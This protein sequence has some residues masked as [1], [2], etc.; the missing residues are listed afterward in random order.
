MKLDNIVHLFYIEKDD[1]R[2][3]VNT[4]DYQQTLHTFISEPYIFLIYLRQVPITKVYRQ[5]T[6]TLNTVYSQAKKN[7]LVSE[8]ASDEEKLQPGSRK[9]GFLINLI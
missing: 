2:E 9:K 5:R 4:D 6:S 7:T 3:L 1:T 8:I